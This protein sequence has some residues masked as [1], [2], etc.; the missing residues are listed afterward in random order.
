MSRKSKG[1]PTKADLDAAAD[2]VRWATPQLNIHW[3]VLL[4]RA[5]KLETDF[6]GSAEE[7]SE[8]LASMTPHYGKRDA[9]LRLGLGWRRLSTQQQA[10]CL[11]HELVHLILSDV[12]DVHRLGGTILP[13][14]AYDILEVWGRQKVELA[15][16]HLA[17]V[18]CSLMPAAEVLA[19][20]KE[21]HG[22]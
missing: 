8:V 22:A 7:G 12:A 11:I 13:Q 6:N 3:R 14:K 4:K 15:T 16:D 1:R 21:E 10:E 20:F 19:K 9:T 5:D 17:L 2:F 18:L